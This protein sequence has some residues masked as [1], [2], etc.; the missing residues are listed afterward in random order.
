LLF[1]RP[2]FGRN[3]FGRIERHFNLLATFQHRHN[4]AGVNPLDAHGTANHPIQL[5]KR[6]RPRIDAN[7]P[8]EAVD[9]FPDCFPV[10]FV[11]SA[12]I[13]SPSDSMAFVIWPCIA[14]F[15]FGI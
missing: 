1:N 8:G 14:A 12:S 9:D 6:E 11:S 4:V 5:A 7:Y 13:F 15:S 10:A 3:E 2:M